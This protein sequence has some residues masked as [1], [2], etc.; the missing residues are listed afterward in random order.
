[1]IV[2]HIK[3]V[4]INS[5]RIQAESDFFEDLDLAVWPLVRDDLNRL[6]RKL[7]RASKKT[8]ERVEREGL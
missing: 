6:H 4:G 7:K 5:I 1:M 8:L 2:V 3:P